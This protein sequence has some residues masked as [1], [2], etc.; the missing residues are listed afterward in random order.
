MPIYRSRSA[1]AP[2]PRNRWDIVRG[3]RQTYNVAGK[4]ET[5]QTGWLLTDAPT[6][7][8]ISDEGIITADLRHTDTSEIRELSVITDNEELNVPIS[9]RDWCITDGDFAQLLTHSYSA[10]TSPSD[11]EVG[12]ARLRYCRDAIYCPHQRR[13]LGE[14]TWD[15]LRSLE[16]NNAGVIGNQHIDYRINYGKRRPFKT[17][18]GKTG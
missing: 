13:E 9:V 10:W 1:G 11:T 18:N 7:I 8:S 4:F 15:A 3:T 14:S 2:V 16:Y 12:D 6:G 17:F 5:P